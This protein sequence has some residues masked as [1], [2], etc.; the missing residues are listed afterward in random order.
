MLATVQLQKKIIKSPLNYIGGKYK[1]LPQILPLFPS[2]IEKFVDLFTGG[3]NVAIN[4]KADEIYCNDNLTYLVDMYKSFQDSSKEEIFF[5]IETRIE[6]FSLSLENEEGYKKLRE[7]Y[8][9]Y[10]KP[11]D[12]FV[13]IAF[14][15]N[16]QI[17]FNN[18]HLFNN[19]FGKKK[20]SFNSSMRINLDSFLSK[21]NQSSI[22]FSNK[23]FNEFD[24][25]FLTYK[26]FVYCDPPYLITNG[27][28][29]DGKRGFTGWNK[30]EEILLFEILD[31]LNFRNIKFALSN[32]LEH[33]GKSNTLLIDWLDKNKN[34][35][36]HFI[37]NNYSNS[38]Y[39]TYNRAKNASKEI[40]VTNY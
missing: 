5:H 35:K 14:T 4:V 15:F 24:F 38:N 16:H 36:T 30:K 20:S 21:I 39:Q 18:N 33:K 28:Y 11:L 7:E 19:P 40:L 23:N 3:C 17:R 2:K 31:K 34:Y 26:D 22:I 29:N 13:L 32:V 12:L 25:S 10:K 6:Q 8:N 1:I 9:K 37:N 27:T